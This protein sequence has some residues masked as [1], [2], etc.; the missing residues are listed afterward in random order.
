MAIG[1]QFQKVGQLFAEKSTAFGIVKSECVEGVEDFMVTFNPAI[2]GFD[3]DD[4]HNN[5]GRYAGLF[6]DLV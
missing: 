3:T 6:T 4:G 2:I 1:R 5:M